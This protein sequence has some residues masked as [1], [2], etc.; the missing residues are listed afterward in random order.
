MQP[1]PRRSD[2]AA[3]GRHVVTSGHKLLRKSLLGNVIEVYLHKPGV[4]KSLAALGARLHGDVLSSDQPPARTATLRGLE[5][6][7]VH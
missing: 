3:P 5:L 1:S 6:L 7:C 4:E 2:R